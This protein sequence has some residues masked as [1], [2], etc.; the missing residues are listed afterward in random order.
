MDPIL[1]WNDVALEANKVSHTVANGE[2]TGPTLSSRALAIV[3]LAMHDAFFGVHAPASH[4]LYLP[5]GTTLPPGSNDAAAVT[6][7]ASTALAALYPSQRLAFEAALSRA[8][9]PYEDASASGTYGRAVADAIIAKLAIKASEPGASDNGYVASFAACR[10]RPDP[11]NPAQ[12][13]HAPFYGA[14]AARI[15]V[16]QDHDL[17]APPS[18]KTVPGDYQAALEEVIGKGAAPG[19]PRLTRTPEETMI[20]LFWAYD[21]ASGIGTPPRLY[22][23]ILRKIAIGKGNTPT[24]NA[25]LFALVNAA[26]GDAGILAWQEKYRWDL[27]RPVLGVREHDECCGPTAEP[28]NTLTENC[29][30]FW[31]PLGAPRTNTRDKPFTPPFPAYPSGHATFGAAAF[32][33]VRRFYGFTGSTIDDLVFDFVSDELNGVSTDERGTVRTRHERHF[34]SLWHAIFENAVSRVYLGVHWVFDSFAAADVQTSGSYKSPSMISYPTRIGGV[35][36][37]LRIADDIYKSKL[38][39]STVQP[40]QAAAIA[41]AKADVNVEK[42]S[43]A[44]AGD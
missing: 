6:A 18:L 43:Y 13:F 27:W 16:T 29:D 22:N 38:T 32:H 12:R 5:G 28:G 7:A 31:L 42:A 24:Q 30:P 17:L 9:I 26:M 15:A 2:Q 23:Q 34:D 11:D 40:P 39:C 10:H 3:H 35:N 33:M 19:H 1:F 41:A 14:T 8:E 21:G 4:G 37:G 25:R 44:R 20:G 36:L